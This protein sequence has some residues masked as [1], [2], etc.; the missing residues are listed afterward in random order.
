[1]GF[2][3]SAALLPLFDP[4]ISPRSFVVVGTKQRASASASSSPAV[5][6]VAGAA[7]PV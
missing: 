5:A 6:A 7:A 3:A 4:E 2:A 1:M